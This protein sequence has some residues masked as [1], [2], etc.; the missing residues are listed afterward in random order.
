MG[1]RVGV[2]RP[3]DREPD[4]LRRQVARIVT[5]LL[6]LVP[7]PPIDLDNNATLDQQ[8]DAADTGD[9]D[10]TFA[11]KT[12]GR[13]RDTGQRFDTRL[14]ACIEHRKR[15][16]VPSGYAL[17]QAIDIGQGHQAGMQGAV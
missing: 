16:P 7:A 9:A 17:E 13:K 12:G 2:V 6:T 5:A 11:P 8:L 10:L 4:A 15:Y 1:D 14:G 3:N